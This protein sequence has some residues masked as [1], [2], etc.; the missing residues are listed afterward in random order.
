MGQ[1]D[2]AES[3]WNLGSQDPILVHRPR[4]H[5]HLLPG[6]LDHLHRSLALPKT[7]EF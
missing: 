2:E 1:D 6:K 5:A 3:V 4:V 7:C